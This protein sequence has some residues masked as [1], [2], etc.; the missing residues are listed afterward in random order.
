MSNTKSLRVQLESD[1]ERKV[2]EIFE[3]QEKNNKLTTDLTDLNNNLDEVKTDNCN[4]AESV[5]NLRKELDFY[6]R[7]NVVKDR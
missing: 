7:L 3:T 2:R 6:R 4:L 1:Y 5:K